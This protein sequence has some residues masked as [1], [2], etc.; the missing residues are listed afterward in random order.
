MP[1]SSA[2]EPTFWLLMR[3]KLTIL[4]NRVRQLTDQTPLQLLMVLG[5][6]ATIWLGLY[7]IFDQVFRFIRR[8]EK[9]AIIALP[10]V[11]HL[12]FF[13]MTI[14]LGFSTAVLVYGSLFAREEPAF[15][16]TTPNKPRNIV[17]VMYVEALFFSSWSLVLLG[18]PLMVAIGSVQGLPWHF[19]AT[20]IGAF[21]GFVPIPGAIGLVIALLI[22]LFLPRMAKRSLMYASAVVL[23]LIVAFW[24]RLWVI[25]S[26]ESITRRWVHDLLGEL[27]YLKSV[28]LPSTWVSKAIQFSIQDNPAEAAFYLGMTVLTGLCMSHWAISFVAWKL[29]PAFGRAHSAPTHSRKYT[30]WASRLLTFVAFFYLSKRM[31]AVILK[32]VRHFLRDPVQWSQLAILFGLLSLYLFY[33]PRSKPDGFSMQWQALICFMNFVAITL[34]LSTFTSRFV[35]PMVSL[36]GKQIWLAGLWPLTRSQVMW[37]KFLYALTVTAAAAVPVTY[38]SIRAVELPLIMGIAQMSATIGCC[39]GLC[40]LAIGLGARWP[41]FKE[42]TASRISSGLGGTINLIA[43]VALVAVN[44]TLF[45]VTCL[46]SMNERQLLKLEWHSAA[47]LSAA[48][49]ASVGSAAFC[50]AI[51][52]RRFRR[53][54]F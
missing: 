46:Y 26:S 3:L 49:V 11:F 53:Q 32:D 7:L 35:F 30:G 24:G 12:F 44:G 4:R 50:M 15:L 48:I 9:E 28:M 20:F 10:Y 17:A 37:A 2:N 23:M 6:L 16:L 25:S 42:P 19:Y 14:L 1:A 18:I 13:S 47:A 5:F 22:A 31:R 34:I 39:I 51:G 52:I 54:E 41:N 29:K 45:A 40:G 8:F 36:E 27:S 21:L 33:L 43:S 38:L